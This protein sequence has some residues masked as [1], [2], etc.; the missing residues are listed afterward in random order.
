[1]FRLLIL[2]TGQFTQYNFVAYDFYNVGCSHHT[3]ITYNLYDIKSLYAMGF[4]TKSHK[5][6][7]VVHNNR[8]HVKDLIN[9]KGN[10]CRRLVLGVIINLSQV[11][12][13]NSVLGVSHKPKFIHFFLVIDVTI[14]QIFWHSESNTGTSTLIF[15]CFIKLKRQ[16][17]NSTFY[18]N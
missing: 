17:K 10:L 4:K 2:A 14:S 3:K 15:I 1:M 13:S 7:C 9:T 12:P 8:K 11:V 6:F 5:I 18:F 16:R